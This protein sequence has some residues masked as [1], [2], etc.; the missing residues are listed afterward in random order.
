VR[1]VRLSVLQNLDKPHGITNGLFV[2]C[3][4]V[5]YDDY[6]TD[7]LVHDNDPSCVF[8][9]TPLV[10]G[11]D[12]DT[13]WSSAVAILSSFESQFVWQ[14]PANEPYRPLTSEDIALGK[15]SLSRVVPIGQVA[16]CEDDENLSEMKWIQAIPL[17]LARASQT[18][19]RE[20]GSLDSNP[21]GAA[22]VW[23]YLHWAHP[24]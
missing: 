13:G 4:G 10:D 11:R 2:E 22:H 5:L 17:H 20:S 15:E 1:G 6:A 8:V 9:K 19:G 16:K 21:R 18:A 7:A 3:E 24:R 12:M 14:D 23:H